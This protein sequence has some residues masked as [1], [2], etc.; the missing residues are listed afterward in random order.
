MSGLEQAVDRILAD[1]LRAAG[2]DGRAL[3]YVGTDIPLDLLLATGRVACHL[4]WT[5]ARATPVADQWLESSFPGWAR[6]MIE[7]WAAGRF[8]CFAQVIFSRGGDGMQRLYYYVCELQ[9]RG[10]IGGPQPLIFDIAMI[11]RES[12]L[13]HTV[14]AVRRLARHLGV[15]DAG[16]DSGIRRAN[17]R[18]ALFERIA[19]A[20]HCKGSL[21]EKIARATLFEDLDALLENADWPREPVAGRI[22]LAGSAPPDDQLHRAVERAGWSVTGEMHDLALSRHGPPVAMG[23]DPADAIGRQRHAA[24]FGTRGFGDAAAGLVA[25]AIRVQAGAVLLWLT[26]E[27]EALAWKVPAQRAQLA[28]ARIPALVMTAR[29]WDG[30][31]GAADEIQRFLENLP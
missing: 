22:L 23:A 25:E 8:D 1:P 12:S 13:R 4:P 24:P 20:R 29:R 3:G 2:A 7:D 19:S 18:R 16:L 6:S 27:D 15:D 21:Y 11:P 28:A 14:S 31:D 26:R 17:A 9:R 5:A 10:Q 30:S